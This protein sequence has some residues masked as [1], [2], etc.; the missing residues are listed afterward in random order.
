MPTPSAQTPAPAAEA[1]ESLLRRLDP[2]GRPGVV[3]VYHAVRNI[4]Y[5]STGE[6]DP[7]RV[8]QVNLGSCSGKHILL[9]D[10]LRRVGHRADVITV[11]AYFNKGF[12]DHPGF[13]PEMRRIIRAERVPDF[14]HYVRLERDGRVQRLDATWDD[15]L[16]PYGFP[17]NRDWDGTGDT[18][19]AA[20]PIRE[21]PPREDLAAFKT[22]LLA[23]L[24]PEQ[25]ELRLRF[26]RLVTE[27][28]ATL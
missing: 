1:Y 17:V 16:I 15:K 25:R 8:L 28:M 9:R 27:W 21:Y 13:P 24:S 6:R 2:Q 7:V 12:P 18:R 23:T 10:L 14:H 5:G 22:E 26:L 3:R 20:E 19:L 4:P 11:F